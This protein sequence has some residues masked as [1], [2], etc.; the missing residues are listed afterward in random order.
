MPDATVRPPLTRFLP[1]LLL[2]LTVFGPISMD[3]YLPAPPALTAELGA[4]TSVA[5]LTVTACLVALGCG[6]LIAGALP[7]R[8]GGDLGF[9]CDD[10]TAVGNSDRTLH[11]VQGGATLDQ[12]DQMDQ[13]HTGLSVDTI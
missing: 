6:Q 3:L 7:D 2:L 10:T 12:M 8:F 5:Q 4:A 9:Y 13:V 11:L 1:L